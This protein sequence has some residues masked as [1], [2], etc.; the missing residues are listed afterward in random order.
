M[1]PSFGRPV[2][3]WFIVGNRPGWASGRP[4]AIVSIGEVITRCRL[5]KSTAT[6][7]FLKPPRTLDGIEAELKTVVG[8]IMTML[9]G[10]AESA[11]N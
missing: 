7:M 5:H 9:G 11:R 6:S 8:C 2:C 1:E 10:L 4:A 3:R